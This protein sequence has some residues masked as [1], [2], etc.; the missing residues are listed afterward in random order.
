[1]NNNHLHYCKYSITYKVI[2][3]LK[4]NERFIL[5]KEITWKEV[6]NRISSN[7]FCPFWNPLEFFWDKY[8]SSLF[9][10]KCSMESISIHNTYKK[11]THF[12][13]N[14]FRDFWLSFLLIFS[15]RSATETSTQSYW[16]YVNHSLEI[17]RWFLQLW[18]GLIFSLSTFL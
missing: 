16:I 15:L 11:Q 1:M 12:G 5:P 7:Y 2:K 14:E 10:T 9:Q 3:H 4:D 18:T 13:R 17:S 8:W 6:L